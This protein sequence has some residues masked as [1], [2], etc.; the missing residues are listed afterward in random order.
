MLRGAHAKA[1][2]LFRINSEAHVIHRY[3]SDPAVVA[4]IAAYP[5]NG[6]GVDRSKLIDFDWR[7]NWAIIPQ[8]RRIPLP[9]EEI[10][11][12]RSFG[13]PLP[14]EKAWIEGLER[15][16]SKIG[17]K[18]YAF[19]RQ[20]CVAVYENGTQQFIRN[21]SSTQ[22]FKPSFLKKIIG[23]KRTPFVDNIVVNRVIDRWCTPVL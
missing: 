18:E 4:K 1:I 5:K 7:Q 2:D 3:W 9:Q 23:I 20:G 14:D 6:D 22:G 13:Q 12:G 19:I 15:Y 10:L 17:V 8:K 21:F 11:E 16:L